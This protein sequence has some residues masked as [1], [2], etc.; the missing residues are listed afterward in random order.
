VST[1]ARR[2]VLAH[3]LA[4]LALSL[5]WPLL[6]VLVAERTSSPLALGL[7]GAARMLPYVALSWCAGRLADRWSRSRLVAATLALRAVLLVVAATCLV[8]DRVWAALV[9]CTLAVAVATPAFPALVASVPG[10]AGRSRERVTGLLVTVEVAAFVVGAALGGMLLQ[11]ATRSLLPW[12]PVVMTLAAAVALRGVAM[13]RPVPRT[14]DETSGWAA[15][16]RSP[17]AV[18]AV[19]VMGAVNLVASLLAVALLPLALH[20]WGAGETGYGVATGVFGLAA[21]AGP[22]LRVLA[23]SAAVLVRRALLLMAIGTLLVVPSPT[24]GWAVVPLALAGAAAVAVESGATAVLQQEVPDH[25]R[26]TVLGI[27]D[28]VVVAAALVGA[29]LAPA[30]V[31]LTGGPAVLGVL[32]LG[33]AATARWAGRATVVTNHDLPTPPPRPRAAAG[34]ARPDRVL[35][36]PRQRDGEHPVG[37]SLGQP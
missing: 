33:L 15:L 31:A 1:T 9:A 17:G 32:A 36:I 22:L 34:P 26:A 23:T 4:S 14:G 27:N 12:V 35:R 6:L 16:R 28:T 2:V 20:A 19:A 5:P 25:V 8:G 10:F 30:A 37:R 11:P 7:A 3:A 18:R 29:L 24:V 21:L 13:P